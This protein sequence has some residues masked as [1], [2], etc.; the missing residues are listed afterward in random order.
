MQKVWV[1][2]WKF[3]WINLEKIL[4]FRPSYIC[5]RQQELCQDQE[6]ICIIVTK[7]DRRPIIIGISLCWVKHETYWNF[8]QCLSCSYYWGNRM[9]LRVFTS[10]YMHTLQYLCS[11]TF[12]NSAKIFST[13]KFCSELVE[14]VISASVPVCELVKNTLIHRYIF[15]K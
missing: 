15:S 11:T 8:I 3:K 6:G 2:N 5:Y 7:G 4:I 12:E 9:Y 10:P 13:L 14:D 1:R